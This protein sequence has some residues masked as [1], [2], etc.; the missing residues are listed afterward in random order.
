MEVH[1][2]YKDPEEGDINDTEAV[3][4][5]FVKLIGEE[6][7]DYYRYEFM[8]TD[9]PEEVW[10]EDFNVKPACLVNELKPEDKYVTEI[11]V[12]KTK[13]KF[14]LI[15][16]NCCYSV[17]DGYDMIVSIA[18]ENIDEY[19]EFPS[20]GRLYFMF[21]DSYLDVEEKLARKNILFIS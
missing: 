8:F 10:G 20:D 9:N 19:D 7:D 16:N 6:S 11:H 4:L 1:K 14:D 17:S 21:G 15:Q 18:S 13:I 5:C 12:V 3:Y 2:L